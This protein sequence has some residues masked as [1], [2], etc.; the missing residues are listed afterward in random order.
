LPTSRHLPLGVAALLGIA[1]LRSLFATAPVDNRF[2]PQRLIDHIPADLRAR[3]VFNDYSMGGPLIADGIRPYIDGRADMYGDAFFAD[4][5]AIAN[6][7]AARFDAAVS[8]YDLRWTVLP[9]HRRLVR[10]LDRSPDWKRLY[11]DESGV[12]HVR[13][14]VGRPD[15]G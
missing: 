7:D 3:P 1:A 14:G 4:Y 11:S 2:N 15:G 13:T 10:L 8:R 6:G 12:I 5:I 9:P